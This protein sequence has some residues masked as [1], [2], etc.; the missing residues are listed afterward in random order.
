[1]LD[2]HQFRVLI[3]PRFILTKYGLPQPW[4]P[5][6]VQA[7]L[8]KAR[9]EYNNNKYHIYFE[10]RRVWGQKPLEPK[11]EKVDAEVENV[12]AEVENVA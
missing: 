5:E 7:L 6:E 12:D 8:A 10:F 11:A 4:S 1:M 3:L 2:I 9:S